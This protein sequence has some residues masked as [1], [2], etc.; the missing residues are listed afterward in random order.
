MY[1]KIKHK[2]T[3]QHLGKE[4]VLDVAEDVSILEAALDAGIELPHDCKLGN[5]CDIITPT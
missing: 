1:A 4:T 3:I 2:V 5:L